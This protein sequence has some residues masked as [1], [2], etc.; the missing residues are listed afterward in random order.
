MAK[1]EIAY[2]VSVD[3]SKAGKSLSELKK[4]F[5]EQ[6]K[7]LSN[8]TTGTKEYVAQLQ[9][10][11]AIKDDIGDLNQTIKAFNPDAKFA[12][13]GK[14][15]GG[16]AG[17][18]ATAQGAMALFDTE[19]K[20]LEKTLVRVQAAMAFSQG[21]EG[22]SGLGDAFK[23]LWLIIKANPVGAIITLLTALAAIAVVVYESM[24]KSSEATK[25]LNNQ[26]AIQKELVS[27]LSRET[28]RQVDLLKSQGASEEKIIE[29]K[30]QLAKAQILELELSIQSHQ[31]KIRDVLDNNTIYESIL[32]VQKAT[33]EKLG[34][35]ELAEGVERQIQVNKQGRVKE[36]LEAIKTEKENLKDLKNQVE[37]LGN[38]KITIQNKATQNYL[39]NLNKEKEAQAKH[40]AE[41][42]ALWNESIYNKQQ[43]EINAAVLTSEQKKAIQQQEADDLLAM[44][45]EFR[46]DDDAGFQQHV[47]A[48]AAMTQ[49]EMSNSLNIASQTTNSLQAL[50]NLYF[51]NK[52]RNLTKGS[53]E[54]LA[55]A[56]KQFKIN[57]ALQLSGAI[58]D[59]AKAIT[60]SLASSPLA[61]GPVP[62]PVGIASLAAVAISSAVNIAKIAS[63]KFNDGGASGGGGGA[64]SPSLS[65]ASAPS[66]APPTQG[67]TQLN[68]DGTI[69]AQSPSTQPVIKAIVV[70]TDITKTQK[71]VGSIEANAKL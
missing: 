29:L 51:D 58:I 55:A 35:T 6:Q 22:L 36:D 45:E 64:S 32:S 46:S 3:S 24:D 17:L 16:L 47:E 39:D 8:L 19:N 42:L 54:E 71:K 30:Q 28:S 61:I 68:P 65:G 44:N 33:F 1:E 14:A 48:R 13:L 63:A 43:A 62:N 50:S 20:D 49:E 69:K 40:D 53:S 70:E 12:A 2:S 31:A 59:A 38:E 26:L 66:V 15:V 21:I 18:F 60:T 37:I 57:K 5:K 67:S 27:A 9:K 52:R 41:I 56:K 4:E 34:L 10:L 7:E 23:D 11:G 25:S